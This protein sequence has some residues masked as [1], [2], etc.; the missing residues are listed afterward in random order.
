MQEVASEAAQRGMSNNGIRG[1]LLVIPEM[2]RADLIVPHSLD[3]EELMGIMYH[4]LAHI[5][6]GHALPC[7]QPGGEGT[8]LWIPPKRFTKR[9]APFDL[10]ACQRNSELMQR[11]LAWCEADADLWAENLRICGAY[12]AKVF[13]REEV[14]LGL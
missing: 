14:L 1:A 6:A 5:I 3:P 11:Y 4:E 12:G 13:F 2:E 9:K 7:K 10:S 8:G